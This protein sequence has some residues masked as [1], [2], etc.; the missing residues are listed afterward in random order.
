MTGNVEDVEELFESVKALE[1]RVGRGLQEDRGAPCTE[2]FV[3]WQNQW[4]TEQS[5]QELCESSF[6]AKK[7][8][9]EISFQRCEGAFARSLGC[10]GPLARSKEAWMKYRSFAA[11]RLWLAAEK[12]GHQFDQLS[13]ELRIEEERHERHND[14]MKTIATKQAEI[15]AWKVEKEKRLDDLSHRHHE[16]ALRCGY[17]LCA[18][19]HHWKKDTIFRAWFFMIVRIKNQDEWQL[20]QLRQLLASRKNHLLLCLCAWRSFA[21]RSSPWWDA[22]V[23]SQVAA[24]CAQ[25]PKAAKHA[26]DERTHRVAGQCIA[27]QL[28]W[29]LIIILQRWWW[30]ATTGRG[31]QRAKK[32]LEQEG[33]ASATAAKAVKQQLDQQTDALALARQVRSRERSQ[34][35]R[36]LAES[37]E[38]LS[39][40]NA[41]LAR[42]IEGVSQLETDV[43]ELHR[44]LALQGEDQ[45]RA[46]QE[47]PARLRERHEDRPEICPDIPTTSPERNFAEHELIGT[48]EKLVR[49]ERWS[50]LKQTFHFENLR[51]VYPIPSASRHFDDAVQIIKT[52]FSLCGSSSRARRSR[53]FAIP[54]LP[55]S[56]TPLE[57]GQHFS[58][59]GRATFP[60]SGCLQ[61][62][63]ACYQL[64]ARGYPRRL[65]KQSASD[66]DSRGG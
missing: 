41:E 15:S 9:A 26:Q 19:K 46:L 8:K 20:R 34:L 35:E 57:D 14:E 23:L 6:I 13:E 17:W 44:V 39:R 56:S 29:L 40:V 47:L 1:A 48:S 63:Q 58:S 65:G 28:D 24:A 10:Q 11:W 54:K 64:R 30:R 53:D 51:A 33:Q 12:A 7:S 3:H 36:Q 2:L 61:P 18:E 66:S 50:S 38:A 25:E 21:L 37:Q 16:V 27:R 5:R 22:H 52:T 55:G 62:I 4:A 43:Q 32:Q 60:N 49:K 31:L 42:E 59:F 45:L